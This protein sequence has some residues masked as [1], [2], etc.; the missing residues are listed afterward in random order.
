MKSRFAICGLVVLAL[1]VPA[2]VPSPRATG[3]AAAFKK[4]V[5]MTLKVEDKTSGLTLE[6]K[7]AVP[8]DSNAFD[9]VRHTVAIAYKTDAEGGPVVTS[10]C[11]VTAPKGTTWTCS[12]DEK[13]C[14]GGVGRI[15]LGK[16]T[17][18]EWKIEKDEGK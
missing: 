9:A 10:L 15:T 12:I 3:E 8:K 17:L 1:L 6:A 14:K 16:D 2:G 4:D 11:G 13:P 7:K 18:I 5:T